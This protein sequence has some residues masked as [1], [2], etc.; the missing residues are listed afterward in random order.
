[1]KEQIDLRRI[2]TGMFDL[3]TD[4]VFEGTYRVIFI[5]KENNDIKRNKIFVHT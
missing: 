3:Q 1:M 4:V 5:N 2:F